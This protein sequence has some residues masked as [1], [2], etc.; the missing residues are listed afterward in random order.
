MMQYNARDATMLINTITVVGTLISMMY[1]SSESMLI[2]IID[3][4]GSIR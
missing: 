4:F 2:A 3:D 1:R